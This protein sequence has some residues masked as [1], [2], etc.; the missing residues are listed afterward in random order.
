MDD[1]EY[2]DDK[3]QDEDSKLLEDMLSQ[4]TTGRR[5]PKALCYEDI[6]L[7]VMRHP[8]TGE[9]VL[10]M[11]AKLIHHKGADNKPKP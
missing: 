3:A 1:E 5:R 6:M 4:K 7:M 10:A 8:E 11:A 9:D 2:E